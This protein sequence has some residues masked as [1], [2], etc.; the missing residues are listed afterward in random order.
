MEI[1][2]VPTMMWLVAF[3]VGLHTLA[4]LLAARLV[5]EERRALLHWAAFNALLALGL[6]LSGARGP[7]RL[8]LTYNGANVATLLGFAAMR[9][10][11]ELFLRTG[12]SDTVQALW[13]APWLLAL[14]LLPPSREWAALRAVVAFLGQATLLMGM[15]WSVAPALRAE[16]GR[17]THHYLLAPSVLIAGLNAALALR[18]IWHGTEP[19]ELHLSLTQNV[20]LLYAY[21]AG[22]ALFAFG[23]LVVVIQRLT[24]RLREVSQR[25]ELTG[26]LNRRAMNEFLDG[27]WHRHLRRRYPLALVMVDLDHFKRVNDSQGHAAGDAVLQRTAALFRQHLRR[28]DLVARMG[29]EEFLLLLPDTELA[30]AQALCERLRAL[31][32]TEALGVTMSLGLTMAAP[33]DGSADVAVRR[34]DTALYRAKAEG[35]DRLVLIEP[36]ALP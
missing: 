15:A 13:L 3:Q 9:R 32:H 36:P 28:E 30:A 10:G 16:F 27:Q 34:A 12:R 17:R 7:E 11:S 8:W 22:S 26:L 23:F 4:W 29:G 24:L 14:L 20:G 35:R 2:S 19:L 5:P 25:D 18:Q 1:E 6:L 33:E 21:L 31:A